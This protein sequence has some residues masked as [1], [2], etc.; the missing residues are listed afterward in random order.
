MDIVLNY[1]YERDID[2]LV[3]EE[4]VSNKEFA[5]IFFSK[6]GMRDNEVLKAYHSLTHISLGESDITIVIKNG[7]RKHALLIENKID[8]IA[9]KN[10]FM[11]YQK[12]GCLGIEK[13]EYDSFDIFIICPKEYLAVN[14]EAKLYPYWVTYE[15]FVEYFSNKDDYRSDYKLTVI[16]K[17]LEKK[18]TGYQVIEHK[19]I[20]RFW[21]SYYDFQEQNFP[22]LYLNRIKGPRGSRAYWPI[23]KTDNKKIKI[24][25]K[26]DRG[27]VDLT[28]EGT[29]ENINYIR[30]LLKDKLDDDMTIEKTSKST[31]VRIKVPKINFEGDFYHYIEELFK[32]FEAINRLHFFANELD[33]ND[34]YNIKIR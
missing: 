16:K 8:A 4:I 13:Q 25:H 24:M 12:R 1:V 22:H 26:A 32:V 28:F 29:G 17:A 21:E 30:K 6:I 14:E 10:Q 2:L 34:I 33:Y 3:I 23:F 27:Y 7:E 31:S 20:T 15:E 9:M 5:N 19:T 18:S 11:R